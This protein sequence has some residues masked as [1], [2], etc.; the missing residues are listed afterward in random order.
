M[1][2]RSIGFR[3]WMIAPAVALLVLLAIPGASVVY[4]SGGGESCARCHEIAPNY[5]SWR[6]SSHKDVACTACHGDAFTLDPD[7]HLGSLRR[8]AVHFFGELPERIH[9]RSRDVEDIH[10]RCQGCHER[11]ASGWSSGGHSATYAQIFLRARHNH[12]RPLM[13]DCLRCHGMFQPGDIAIVVTPVN[14]EGPWTLVEPSPEVP[15]IPCLSC[16]AVHVAASGAGDASEAGANSANWTYPSLGLYDR[17]AR[18]HIHAS[19]LP[20]PEIYEGQRRVTVDNSPATALCYQ[21]HAPYANMQARTNDDKTP[22]GRYEGMACLRCH[23][24]HNLKA[25]HAC[26]D[27]HRNPAACEDRVPIPRPPR[28]R[29]TR[30]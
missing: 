19:L 24:S 16:H 29:S 6:I 10:L 26:P 11:A 20:G 9:L 18:Q 3:R 13:D 14:A 30:R 23:G 15:T 22:L 28:P 5:E 8:I 12:S 1:A 27:F 25:R 17:R 21:C 4:E 2:P 7:F